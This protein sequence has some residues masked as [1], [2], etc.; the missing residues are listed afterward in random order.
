MKKYFVYVILSLILF[1]GIYAKAEAE[2]KNSGYISLNASKTK[3]VE[4]NFA[5]VSFAVENTADTAQK[6][7]EKNNQVSSVIINAL[8]SVSDSSTDVIK[9]N[10]FSVNPVYSTSAGKRVIKNYM[11]V[12]SVTIETKD[13]S[14]VAV[15][16]DT[17]I[18]NG[19]N[20]TNGLYYSYENDNG[21][22]QD[23][24]PSL[25]KDLRA[26]A[27]SIAKAAGTVVTG[28]KQIGASCS[29]NMAVSNGRFY[30]AKMMMDSA[31]AES[32]ISTPVE[33]GKVKINVYVN[34]DFYVR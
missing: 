21:V 12:N 22:C 8:K 13:T 30:S 26:Q 3:E 32:A 10:N 17:A 20:R 23:I 29:T 31:N 24:Y 18:K 19:A 1:G 9:T 33:A 14:K 16:I 11:A 28:V 15:F 7:A 25:L 27:D 4:P 6:A 34:A 2:V 5:R